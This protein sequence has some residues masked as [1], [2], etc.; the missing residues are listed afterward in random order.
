MK[1]LASFLF[2]VLAALLSQ[3]SAQRTLVLMDSMNTRETHSHFFSKLTDAGLSLKYVLADSSSLNLQRYGELLFENLIIFSPS[4]E[5]YGG[6]VDTDEI[7]SFIDKGGNVLVAGSSDIGTPLRDLANELG[8]EYDDAGNGVVDHVHHADGDHT[9]VTTTDAT[10]ADIITGGAVSAIAPVLFRGVGMLVDDSNPLAFAVLRASATAY[11]S[12][13]DNIFSSSDDDDNDDD[14]EESMAMGRSAVLAGAMQ[15]RNNARVVLTGSLDMFANDLLTR[16]DAANGVFA[17]SLALWC[18]GER[19][20]LRVGSGGA[21]HVLVSSGKSQQEY[22]VTEEV[23]YSLPLEEKVNGRW[24]PYAGRDVQ[25]EFVRIDPFVRA[26]LSNDGGDGVQRLR[27]TLP[28]VYGVFQF[29]VDYER[30]GYT[31]VVDA[32]QVSV[33]PLRHTQYERFIVSAYPYYAS[34]FSMMFG[35]LI[36]SFVFLH[37]SRK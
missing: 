28:D 32:Q 25:L 37:H 29:R 16:E 30:R 20:Q 31:H 18:F 13:L 11:T 9:L 17:P 21:S 15:A 8:F 22:T 12:N 24:V 27:F 19:G 10:S 7:I 35:L 23:D 14:E 3:T 2:A 34:A 1:A 26:T 6:S 36:F 5:Q 4:V 33:R